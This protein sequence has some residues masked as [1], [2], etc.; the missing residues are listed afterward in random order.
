MSITWTGEVPIAPY[1]GSTELSGTATGG[2]TM[3]MLSKV[4]KTGVAI[5]AVQV[6]KREAS[7]PENQRK[8]QELVA[9]LRQQPR[10]PR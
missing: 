2:Y 9:K 10:G 3:G 1:R 5:K 6:I 8:A 4:L 7:K